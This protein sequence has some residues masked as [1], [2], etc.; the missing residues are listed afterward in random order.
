MMNCPSRECV[1]DLMPMRSHVR[2]P[3][4][5]TVAE[6]FDSPQPAA[7]KALGISL[8]SMKQVR[9]EP[10]MMSDSMSRAARVC[11][12]MTLRSGSSVRTNA[13]A[14]LD[15]DYASTGVTLLACVNESWRVSLELT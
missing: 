7:A 5:R 8:T 10:I 14:A 1:V 4:I 3:L 15:S 9:N 11:A 13:A 6:L 2:S 12:C